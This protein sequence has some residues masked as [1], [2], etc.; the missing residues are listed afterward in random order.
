[1]KSQSAEPGNEL[2]R[3]LDRV[4]QQE[5]LYA[6]AGA[7]AYLNWMAA[8]EAALTTNGSTFVKLKKVAQRAVYASIMRPVPPRDTCAT[9]AVRR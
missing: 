2:S 8:A 7:E 1:V 4:K 3:G 5:A 6:E 9:T